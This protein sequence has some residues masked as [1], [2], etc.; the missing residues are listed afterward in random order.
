M[1]LEL[2]CFSL[3]D[4]L[5]AKD[6][7]VHRIEFCRDYNLGGITP[8]TNDFK[9][10]RKATPNL[11]IHVMI[12]LRGGNFLYSD[13]E[14]MTMVNQI[15]TFRDLGVDGFVFGALLSKFE[16]AQQ[17]IDRKAC[18]KL[19]AAAKNKPCVFHRAF[20]EVGHIETAMSELIYM[21]FSAI[22]SSGG[23][24]I[25]ADNVNHLIDL[26]NA[27]Q[28]IEIIVGGGVRSS[29]VCVFKDTSITW[30]HSAAWDKDLMTMDQVEVLDI[31][32]AIN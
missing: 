20:D 14:L 23:T 30:L 16:G 27:N 26:Q 7:G 4:A 21:G 28:Q 1:F 22:L 29:N 25:A 32:K 13:E 3:K 12:R 8:D 18:K 17:S 10:L 31:L 9:K 24:H 6:L 2:A 11:P 19:M 5:K 15:S